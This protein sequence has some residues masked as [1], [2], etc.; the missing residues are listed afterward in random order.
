MRNRQICKMKRGVDVSSITI[1]G[2]VRE[3]YIIIIQEMRR[4]EDTE[5]GVRTKEIFLPEKLQKEEL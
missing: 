1:A 5:K 2:T 3:I 4:R